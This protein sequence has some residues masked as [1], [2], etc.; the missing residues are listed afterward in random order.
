MGGR[1]DVGL[2]EG[3]GTGTPSGGRSS[4]GT[5]H[6]ARAMMS[7]VVTRRGSRTVEGCHYLH[8][9]RPLQAR[10]VTRPR[11]AGQLQRRDAMP[12]RR[13]HG[14]RLSHP[15]RRHQHI[16]GVVRR[17]R[18]DVDPRL[19]ERPGNRRQ[20]SGQRQVKRPSNPQTAPPRIDNRP[21]RREIGSTDHG[22]LH[23]RPRDRGDRRGPVIASGGTGPR[24]RP[25]RGRKQL[26]RNRGTS[27][28]AAHRKRLR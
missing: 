3:L 18:K 11:P 26:R 12:R 24:T 4:G 21:S 23:R 15:H 27:G 28:Q 19:G 10:M 5:P 22:G 7:A 14:H 13:Q 20:N 25:G 16:V 8:T 9:I 2:T 17:E 6:P 1:T